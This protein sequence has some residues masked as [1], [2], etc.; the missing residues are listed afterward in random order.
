MADVFV[1]GFPGAR[2][3]SRDDEDDR[4][5]EANQLNLSLSEVSFD[6]RTDAEGRFTLRHMPVHGHIA[7]VFERSG[8]ARKF[9]TIDV[10]KE[11]KN[12]VAKVHSITMLAA[13]CYFRIKIVDH[14]GKPVGTGAVEAIDS[15]RY[16]AG[17][18]KVDKT[19][20]V[21]IGIRKAGRLELYYETDP[22]NPRINRSMKADIADGKDTPVVEIRLPESHWLAG[23]SSMR[24]LASPSLE[25]TSDTA[26]R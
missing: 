7:V 16:G 9:I 5:N 25:R 20:E 2:P 14:A 13:Q 19:G 26:R 4:E 10:G 3:R 22:L 17:R 12:A 21:H 1:E 23:A 6:V 8:L 15:D 18:A 11:S 24:T